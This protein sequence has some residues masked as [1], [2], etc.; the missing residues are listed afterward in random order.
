MSFAFRVVKD[1][2]TWNADR[3][4]RELREVR[5]REV[6]I[7]TG[8]EPAYPQTSAFMRRLSVDLAADADML[9]EAF[10]SLSEGRELTAEQYDLIL[11]AARSLRPAP[12]EAPASVI[13]ALRL[14]EARA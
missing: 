12:T 10:A 1:G 11:A 2:D 4:R 6:S 5:L 8:V 3:S 13:T 7:L 9:A 14:I